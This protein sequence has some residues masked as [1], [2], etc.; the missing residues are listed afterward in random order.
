MIFQKIESFVLNLCPK[1]ELGFSG[2]CLSFCLFQKHLCMIMEYVD[3]GDVG[4]LLK[5]V[6]ALPY[7]LAR[8]YFAETVLAVEYLHSYGI[9]HRDLKPDKYVLFCS[10]IFCFSD[11]HLRYGERH[12]S[13][14]QH[15]SFLRKRTRELQPQSPSRPLVID[16][17]LLKSTEF[18]KTGLIGKFFI[19]LGY[20]KTSFI[21]EK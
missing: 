8:M 20:L 9:V 18:E 4:T 10:V 5:N 1:V 19:S 17:F 2:L 16:N 13:R 7:D 12:W 21:F 14:Q 15:R 11:T 6:G 3:G